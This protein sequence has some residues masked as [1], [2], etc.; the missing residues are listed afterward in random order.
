MARLVSDKMSGVLGQ[1]VVVENRAGGAGGTVGARSVLIAEPDGYTIM[2]CSTSNLLIAPLIYKNVGYNAASFV[3][4]RG[5]SATRRRCWPC[6]P[7]S[8][9]IRWRS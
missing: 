2:L 7:P 6:I 3:P 1:P 4:G 8:R 9:S 5:A